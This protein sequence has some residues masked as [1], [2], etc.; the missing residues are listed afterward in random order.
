MGADGGEVQAFTFFEKLSNST[1]FDLDVS[2][3]FLDPA[4]QGSTNTNVT[5]ILEPI[6]GVQE[7]GKVTIEVFGFPSSMNT[8]FYVNGIANETATQPLIVGTKAN[9]T[10]LSFTP[11]LDTP[12]GTYLV[13]IDAF[14]FGSSF[15]FFDIFVPV[16]P[17]GIVLTDVFGSLTII[18]PFG[19][20]GDI[21]TVQGLGFTPGNTPV[22]TFGG[23]NVVPPAI[24]F[25]SSASTSPG[26]ISFPIAVPA[27]LTS[28]IYPV[29]LSDGVVED[30][31]FFEVI[32]AGDKFFIDTSQGYLNPIVQGGTTGNLTITLTVPPGAD[33]VDVDLAFEG[34]LP[35][36]TPN[37]DLKRDGVFDNAATAIIN[38]TKGG[39]N[40]TIVK[41]ETTLA[42]PPG[43]F[44]I[45]LT[46]ED[47]EDTFFTAI[48]IEIG[49]SPDIG[50]G[51]AF[52]TLSINPS[53]AL[54]G[55]DLILVGTGFGT[56]NSEFS[57]IEISVPGAILPFT[58][59]TPVA[60][61]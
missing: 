59:A 21:I 35:G 28:G 12:P 16:E 61:Q 17:A 43:F 5:L 60:R 4:I 7:P 27:A 54:P 45:F 14:D 9:K 30:T 52:A 1:T 44:D 10:I 34:L 23:I 49:I 19:E 25:G 58:I 55:Q 36:V 57:S 15:D 3:E 6:P 56:G 39:T 42:T 18:P 2:N 37:F 24:T 26:Q 50:G 11:G 32:T 46:A 13:G 41:F 40:S 47:T 51:V 53:T 31:F 29:T 48:P 20:A 8:T 22:V 33:A 38:V